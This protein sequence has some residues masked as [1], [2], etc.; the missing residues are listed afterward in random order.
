M[1]IPSLSELE[2]ELEQ[3]PDLIRDHDIRISLISQISI[4]RE[5]EPLLKEREE[6]LALLKRIHKCK[7]IDECYIELVELLT[8]MEGK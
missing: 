8:K 4:I 1:K 3:Y 5:V 7:D 6:M 2:K